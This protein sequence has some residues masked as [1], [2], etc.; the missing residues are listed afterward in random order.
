MINADRGGGRAYVP[1]MTPER[2]AR[3]FAAWAADELAIYRV[4]YRRYKAT[5]LA[6]LGSTTTALPRGN[7]K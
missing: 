5:V 6:A 3:Y 7:T 4:A 2:A 1:Y